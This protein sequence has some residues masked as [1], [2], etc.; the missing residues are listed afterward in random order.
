MG[1][2]TTGLWLQVVR[3]EKAALDE[4]IG[5]VI[6]ENRRKAAVAA[7]AARA[8]MPEGGGSGAAAAE[9]AARGG[10]G[11]AAAAVRSQGVPPNGAEAGRLREFRMRPNLAEGVAA[12][13]FRSVRKGGR[14]CADGAAAAEVA[15]AEEAE[16][17]QRGT[18]G[19]QRKKKSETRAVGKGQAVEGMDVSEH[20]GRADRR[21][22][23]GGKGQHSGGARAEG[24]DDDAASK[25]RQEYRRRGGGGSRGGEAGLKSVWQRREEGKQR[26]RRVLQDD[27]I[28]DI[29]DRFVEDVE[30]LYGDT[31]AA[32]KLAGGCG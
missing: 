8:S 17:K 1:S 16:G 11:S 4:R 19:R 12:P 22:L 13:M 14:A 26:N 23:A 9:A 3:V 29:F 31:T 30:V 25:E 20:G 15:A 28:D 6:D 32:E 5:F 7:A 10:G 21:S 2:V 27:R 24:D 18:G